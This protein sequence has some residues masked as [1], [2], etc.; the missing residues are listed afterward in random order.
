[1]EIFREQDHYILQTVTFCDRP[2]VAIATTAL[3]KTAS[4]F[5]DHYEMSANIISEK[6]YVHDILFAVKNRVGAQQVSSEIDTTLKV[7]GFQIKQWIMSG[8]SRPYQNSVELHEEKVL[9]M[10]WE[11]ERDVFKF[12]TRQNF[13]P[14]IKGNRHVEN[15]QC[16]EV[17]SRV[18]E[19]LSNRIIPSQVSNIFYPLGLINPFISPIKTSIKSSLL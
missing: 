2:S 19:T 7:G 10:V 3:Q 5:E 11:P 4:M 12:H 15:L 14:K 17:P 6:T 16:H 13:S 18:P 1:M 8:S 9:G